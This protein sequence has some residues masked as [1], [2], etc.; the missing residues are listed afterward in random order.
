[1]S[2]ATGF[3]GLES[4]S[5]LFFNNEGLHLERDSISRRLGQQ[6]AP[7]LCRHESFER[8]L[9]SPDPMLSL[10]LRRE[11]A[12]R[13][14]DRKES[15]RPEQIDQRSLPGND[16]RIRLVAVKQPKQPTV[17]DRCYVLNR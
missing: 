7:W 2:V 8:V 4:I 10:R 3:I 6:A 5:L 15:T 16:F 11:Q 17:S 13:V 1:M 12:Q 9:Q 14:L